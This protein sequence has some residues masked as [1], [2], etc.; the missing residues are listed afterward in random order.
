VEVGGNDWLVLVVCTNESQGCLVGG[1]ANG[2]ILRGLQ[3]ASL[4]GMTVEVKSC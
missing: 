1:G 2:L 3:S 4:L